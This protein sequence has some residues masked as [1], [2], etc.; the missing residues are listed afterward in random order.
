[1]YGQTWGIENKM[2]IEIPEI[3]SS[4]SWSSLYMYKYQ[5]VCLCE[6]MV[7]PPLA[8]GD[9]SSPGEKKRGECSP[10]LQQ[11]MGET[12]CPKLRLQ[13]CAVW[14]KPLLIAQAIGFLL[15]ADTSGF[16]ECR[17]GRLKKLCMVPEKGLKH[18]I[19]K[20]QLTVWLSRTAILLDFL[21][22]I[23]LPREEDRWQCHS[24]FF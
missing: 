3:W 20:S 24:Q 19:Y 17:T 4:M 10:P 13:Q 14:R 7:R 6:E 9:G 11:E 12:F 5:H 23:V 16:T 8:D 1:M 2:H 15:W 18:W 21:K 22:K